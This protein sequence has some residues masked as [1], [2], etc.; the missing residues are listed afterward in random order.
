[1]D[2]ATGQKVLWK[3]VVPADAAGVVDVT[4]VVMTPDGASYAY[5][6]GQILSDLLVVEGVR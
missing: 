1:M 5:S 6:Y 4:S 3:E 2:V